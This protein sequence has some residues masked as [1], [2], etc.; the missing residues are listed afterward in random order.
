MTSAVDEQPS[1]IA[2]GLSASR[3]SLLGFS[4]LVRSTSGTIVQLR[5]GRVGRDEPVIA[6]RRAR[7][8]REAGQV[9]V[10]GAVASPPL[11]QAGLIETEIIELHPFAGL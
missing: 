7:G 4:R 1:A 3:S 2:T 8:D 9:A 10:E 11:A 5:N 6:S